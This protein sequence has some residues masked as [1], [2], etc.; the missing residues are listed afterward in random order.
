MTRFNGDVDLI[1]KNYGSLT[2]KQL[3]VF[4]VK[5]HKLVFGKPSFDYII[6]DRSIFYKKDWSKT[7]SKKYC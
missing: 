5:Y 1:I 4:K 7:L 2:K 3:K 6:D